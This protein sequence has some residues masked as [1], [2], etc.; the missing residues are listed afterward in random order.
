MRVAVE[1]GRR[2]AAGAAPL[3][4]PV[5]VL[6]SSACCVG[7][8][9]VV[10]SWVGLSGS[11]LLALENTLGPYRPWILGAT[12]VSLIVGF[13]SAYGSEPECAPGAVCAR[14][15]SLRARRAALWLAA[16]LMGVLLYLTYV[17]PNLDLYLGVY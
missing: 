11:A 1:E 8:L 2:L 17:H 7:P 16:S 6:L 12:L 3:A 15:G 5:L 13:R 4:S 10:L 14:S 9:A